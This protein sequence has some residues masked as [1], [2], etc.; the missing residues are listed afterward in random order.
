MRK[1]FT[2]LLAG[3]MIFSLGG[4]STAKAPV[5]SEKVEAVAEEVNK[6]E[7]PAPVAEDTET[8]NLVVYCPHPLEFIDPIVAEFENKT[9]VEV[10]VIAAGTGELLK[11]VESEKDNPLGDILWGGSL[12]TVQPKVDLFENYTSANEDAIRDELKNVEGPLTRFSDIPSVIKIGR[13][14]V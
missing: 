3:T 11:R 4:C 7:E 2:M 13:A 9:G 12:S 6:T 1:I 8:K 5:A 14:H 10:E